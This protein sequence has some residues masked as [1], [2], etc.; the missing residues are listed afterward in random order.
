MLRDSIP[1]TGA[2]Y[3]FG[4]RHEVDPL[5]TGFVHEGVLE[6]VHVGEVKLKLG[7]EK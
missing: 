7:L 3:I 2:F 4:D 1:G 5:P 6:P